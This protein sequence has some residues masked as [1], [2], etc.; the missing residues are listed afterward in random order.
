MCIRDRFNINQSQY[1]HN[2]LSRTLGF[3]PKF[4]AYQRSDID[5]ILMLANTQ[6]GRLIR[7]QVNFFSGSKIPVYSTSSIFNGIQDEVNNIDLDDTRFPIMPWVLRSAKVAPYAG[8]L[9]MLFALGTD[10]YSIAPSYS[11]L[12]RNDNLAI[13]GNTGQ[14]SIS[15]YGEA[16]YQPIWARFKNGEVIPIETLGLDTQPIETLNSDGL[17]D[18]RVNGTYNDSTYNS[19]TWDRQSGSRRKLQKEQSEDQSKDTE[20]GLRRSR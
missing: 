1:R 10:A 11:E 18:Q 19:Q 16:I 2:Q 3:K 14:V 6:T 12:R 7:P 15:S 20:D 5:F 4:S 17:T 9:N 8:Q 13:K